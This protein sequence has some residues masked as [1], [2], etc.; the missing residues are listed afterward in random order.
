MS[1]EAKNETSWNESH[2]HDQKMIFI[3]I[4]YK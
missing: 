1:G 3:F 4:I 2:I